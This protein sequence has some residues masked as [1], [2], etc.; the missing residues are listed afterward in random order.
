MPPVPTVWRRLFLYGNKWI[1]SCILLGAVVLRV[2]VDFNED[3]LFR[4]SGKLTDFCL[5][6]QGDINLPNIND[7]DRKAVTFANNHKSITCHERLA[8][9][10]CSWRDTSVSPTVCVESST[11]TSQMAFKKYLMGSCYLFGFATSARYQQYQFSN[12]FSADM[13]LVVVGFTTRLVHH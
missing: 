11:G 3:C 5:F 10:A 9:V 2:T 7:D 6:R 4:R 1:V 8:L 13:R 12:F